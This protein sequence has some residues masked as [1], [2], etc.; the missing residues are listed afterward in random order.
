MTIL[1][2]WKVASSYSQLKEFIVVEM[3]VSGT[4]EVQ[5]RDLCTLTLA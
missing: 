5:V 1:E 2:A 3:L 4:A